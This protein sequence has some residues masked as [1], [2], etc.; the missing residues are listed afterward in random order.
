MANQLLITKKDGA[1]LSVRVE[2]G[3]V[4]QIQA[5]PEDAGSLLGDIYVGKVRNIVKNI[6]AAFVE[7]EQG[8]MGYL[9]LDAKVCPIHTDGVVSDGTRVLIGD[10]IIIQI[11]REAVKTKP[12]TLSGTLNF[13]GKYVVL[14]YGERTVSISSKIKDAERKQQLRGFLR[15]NID[16]DY[17]FVARTNCKDASDEKILKEIAFLKQQLENIKKFGVHR[18]KF[19]C[20]YHAPDAYLCDIRDSYDSLLESIITDDDEIFNRIMEFAKI[21]QPEDIK[22]IKRWDNADGK[23]DAVYDVTKTLEHALMPKV[24]LKN[25]GY[26]VIQPTEALVSIDVNTGKAISKKKDVQKTFL[27]V[28][29]EAATQIA[30]QLRLRNLSGMILIDFIDMKDA[31][32][33]KQLMDRLRTEFA[34]DPVKTIL[35]DMTKLGLV[36][37]TRK[38]VRKSLYEQIKDAQDYSKSDL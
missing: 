13:P 11:E 33:N 1:V 10:E 23:L 29:L 6:N 25:G 38:K 24:W 22:K 5:Q 7:Y 12:P 35:V 21:Y 3:K 9:S 37:V 19:N 18:A 4:A 36:E 28:N 20:L 34:K 15:N 32:Y 30:K 31:D 8:K 27:K 26:L 17:G 2:D 14:I 16:G